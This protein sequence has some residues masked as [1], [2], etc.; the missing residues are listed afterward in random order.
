MPRN[1]RSPV[2]DSLE[3]FSRLA[4]PRRLRAYQLEAGEAIVR[5]VL[6]GAGKTFT[7]MM[8]RQS[9]KN[10]LAAQL[11]AYL[12]HLF[13]GHGGQIVK[14]APSYRPQIINSIIRLREVL[15]TDFSDG[16]WASRH[17]H[18]IEMGNVPIMFFSADRQANVVGATASLLLAIDEAQDVDEDVYWRSFRPMASTTRAT[19]V[20]MEPPGTRTTSSSSSAGTT[21]S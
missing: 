8:A 3:S 7:V 18:S 16:Q 2:L 6:E 13:A 14:A 11:E 15:S 20:L 21:G 4:A 12:L 5:S 10:E 19:T 17:G 1:E 9:G